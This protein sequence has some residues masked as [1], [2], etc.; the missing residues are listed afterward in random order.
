MTSWTPRARSSVARARA[1]IPFIAAKLAE[2]R[3]AG[4]PVIYVCDSHRL[5]DREFQMFPPHAVRGTRGGEVIAELKPRP[6]DLVVA[7]TRYSPF[8]RME[9]DRLVRELAPQE[10]IVL[11]VCASICVMETVSDLRDRDYNVTVCREGVVDFDPQAHDFSLKR[12][13]KTL[14]ARVV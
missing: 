10:V 1:I 14:G 3:R 2:C 13:E 4:E 5:D 12:I 7:K 9:L 6:G 8:F 11:G